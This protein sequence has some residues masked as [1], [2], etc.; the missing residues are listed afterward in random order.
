MTTRR[1]AAIYLP[2]LPCEL[3]AVVKN[4][5]AKVSL[6][7]VSFGVVLVEPNGVADANQRLMAV[8]EAAR[9]H[10]VFEGQTLEEARAIQAAFVVRELPQA[11][12]MLGLERIIDSLRDFDLTVACEPPCTV[13]LVTFR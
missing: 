10:G 1:I 3:A 12:L 13:W 11:A 5:E 4:P 6:S 9:R 7:Q 8:S 2:Q